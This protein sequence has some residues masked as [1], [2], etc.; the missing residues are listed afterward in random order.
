MFRQAVLKKFGS[1]LCGLNGLHS[2]T[3][4][5]DKPNANTKNAVAALFKASRY[6]QV[7]ENGRFYVRFRTLCFIRFVNFLL[8]WPPLL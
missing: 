6:L 8:D 4:L 7:Y 2:D 5:I 1:M 3:L